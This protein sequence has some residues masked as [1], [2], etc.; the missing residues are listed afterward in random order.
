MAPAKLNFPSRDG[1]G[2][3]PACDIVFVFADCR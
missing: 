2:R 3:F 1:A